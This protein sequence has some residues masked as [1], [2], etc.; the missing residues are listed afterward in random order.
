M[1]ITSTDAKILNA[2]QEDAR[3]GLEALAEMT[4]L[5]TATVQRRLK[6]MR[7]DGTIMQDVVLVDPAKVGQGMTM[8]VMVELE[9]ERLDQIDQ[10]TRRVTAD[11]NVQQC[12]YITGEAD[13][14]LVC[15][16]RDIED[17]E[18]L[19]HRLFFDDANVRR[20]RTSVVMS[21]KKVG[22]NVPVVAE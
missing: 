20:F 3:V 12:Y 15:T 13:F 5:S 2:L 6:K 16:A 21:R 1:E 8:V 11:P 4:G 19:T 7:E 17:F 22:L 14:C 18:R 10:F 9:R